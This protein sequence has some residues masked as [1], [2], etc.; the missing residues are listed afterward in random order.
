MK[1]E[2]DIKKKLTDRQ[3]D[4]RTNRQTNR[5]TQNLITTA[6]QNIKL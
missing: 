4:K 1:S 3:T 2:I 5:Q 6:I